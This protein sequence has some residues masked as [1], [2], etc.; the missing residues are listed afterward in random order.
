VAVIDARR[1]EV[2]GAAW[3]LLGDEPEAVLL[4]PATPVIAPCALRPQ[5]LA[6]ELAAHP[7]RAL[8]AGDGAVGFRGELERSGVLVAEDT[9]DAHRVTARHHC[10]LA[11]VLP[12]AAPGEVTPEYLRVPDAELKTTP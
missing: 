2:F 10:R 9:S 8:A 3:P 6:E 11:R 7:G 5:A 1:G 4:D 12:D